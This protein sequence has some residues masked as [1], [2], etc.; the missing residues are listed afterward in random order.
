M[1]LTRRR[2]LQS[3]GMAAAA[4][5]VKSSAAA[6]LSR[7]SSQNTGPGE[8]AFGPLLPDPDGL[9]DLPEGFAYSIISRTGDRMSDGFLVPGHPDGMGVLEG[10]DGK[11]IIMRNHEVSHLHPLS[12][13]PYGDD[14]VLL[15]RM[16]I[17]R[18]YDPGS[19]GIPP[20][21]GVTTMVYDT[22]T[23]SLEKQFLT[24]AG[25]L[26]NCGGNI[27]PWGTWL[28]CEELFE[29]PDDFFLR[30]HGY[31]FEVPVSPKIRLAVPRPLK[32]MGRFLHEGAAVHPPSGAVFQTEDQ[33]D[34]LFYRYLPNR[35]G[36]LAKGRLQCMT[37][38]GDTEADLRNW[39]TTSI[40]RGEK[41][42]VSW[43]TLKDVN[44][45]KDD[46][47]IIGREKG[48]VPF[49]NSEGI[50]QSG[51][52]I[53]FDCTNGGAKKQGQIW[54][55]LPSPFEGTPREEE[56][57]G[58]LELV[59]ESPGTSVLEH[60]DQMT[61]TRW[62]DLFICEDGY[63]EQFLMGLKPDNSTYRFARNARSESE[64]AGVCF[65]PDGTTMFLNMQ[66]EGLT[67][68]VTGKFPEARIYAPSAGS[69]AD[70]SILFN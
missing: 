27:T 35:P 48:G 4:F 39:E 21:A 57:P 31:V 19:R 20:M 67:F 58:R 45:K 8:S 66:H 26:F 5:F 25:T 32:A 59:F 65:S 64:L 33:K 34:G 69:P 9:L 10:P 14:L 44:R 43:L 30:S 52:T 6:D 18:I 42:P 29:G 63:G 22:R 62:G 36:R 37:I 70:P 49:A 17:D 61:R 51:G 41:R 11:T 40:R 54:R 50:F 68:A 38:K 16:T 23:Q 56:E 7:L 28:S 13:G 47:R 24:L 1:R 46:L 55:Y 2:F 60:P 12:M 15:R 53:Y 3:I